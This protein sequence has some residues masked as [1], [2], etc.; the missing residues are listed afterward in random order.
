[1]HIFELSTGMWTNEYQKIK[2]NGKWNTKKIYQGLNC[3]NVTKH[4]DNNQMFF[5][6]IRLCPLTSEY[7]KTD[8]NNYPNIFG[9]NNMYQTNI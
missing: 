7:H 5:F 2:L 8:K 9:C 1:M 6:C 3:S 4:Q